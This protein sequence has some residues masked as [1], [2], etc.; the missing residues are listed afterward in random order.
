MNELKKIFLSNICNECDNYSFRYGMCYN[1]FKQ[2]NINNI[3]EKIINKYSNKETYDELLEIKS[4]ISS[5]IYRINNE[6]NK[7]IIKFKS[8]KYLFQKQ[9]ELSNTIKNKNIINNDITIFNY[10]ILIENIL[11]II[12]NCKN[13]NYQEVTEKHI[14]KNIKNDLNLKNIEYKNNVHNKELIRHIIKCMLKKQFIKNSNVIY[15]NNILLTKLQNYYKD[16]KNMIYSTTEFTID[17]CGHALRYDLYFIIKTNTNDL[18]EVIIETDEDHHYNIKR[19][20]G[21]IYDIYK[22]IYCFENCI[23][24]LRLKTKKLKQTDI[25]IAINFINEII[26]TNFPTYNISNDYIIA[27]NE[28]LKKSEKK[29]L[30]NIIKKNSKI[31]NK[32]FSKIYISDSETE[33]DIEYSEDDFTLY[34][35]TLSDAEAKKLLISK[36]HNRD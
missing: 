7:N 18:F 24:L 16:T 23:S 35:K 11:E 34:I 1:H 33:S 12:K 31:I 13:T 14:S 20:L 17:I 30:D 21:N 4:E 29:E 28:I 36:L 15:N 3:I 6:I 2:L 10:K 32:T 25:N 9:R 8:H 19:Q 27:K 5:N 22:D 26:K